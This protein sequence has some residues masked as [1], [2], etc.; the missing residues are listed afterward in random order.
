MARHRSLRLS[1]SRMVIL[2]LLVAAAGAAIASGIVGEWVTALR[3]IAGTPSVAPSAPVPQIGSLPTSAVP[4]QFTTEQFISPDGEHMTYY[5]YVP[6]N[7]LA[8]QRYP[9]VLLLH[10][11]GERS[12]SSKT[13]AQNRALRWDSNTCGT[14]SRRRCRRGGHPSWSYRKWRAP[15]AG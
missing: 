2:V 4:G 3:T 8:R 5:L 13:A 15:P 9:L 11:G 6:T 12:S 10:G 14:G 1:T 7:A